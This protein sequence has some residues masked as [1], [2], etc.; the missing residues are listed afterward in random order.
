MI[1]T[2]PDRGVASLID[3]WAFATVQPRPTYTPTPTYSLL[4]LTSGDARP[5]LQKKTAHQDESQSGSKPPAYSDNGALLKKDCLCLLRMPTHKQPTLGSSTSRDGCIRRDC[6]FSHSRFGH[7]GPS[8]SICFQPSHLCF[9]VARILFLNIQL[10]LGT[11]Q[12]RGIPGHSG[13]RT[14]TLAHT[15]SQCSPHIN[16]LCML[17][18][19]GLDHSVTTIAWLQCSAL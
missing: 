6:G 15:T 11:V 12:F 17:L 3:R 14:E 1:S 19:P 10:S 18:L 9:S 2:C 5:P 16:R 8:D 7:F 4:V 13:S